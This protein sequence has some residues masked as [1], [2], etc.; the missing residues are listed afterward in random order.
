M[1]SL[2]K[3]MMMMMMMMI[4]GN[5]NDDDDDDGDD[6]DDDDDD[7]DCDDDGDGDDVPT[8]KGTA[9]LFL[10]SSFIPPRPFWQ[11]VALTTPSFS[12]ADSASDSHNPK[13]L[14]KMSV[15]TCSSS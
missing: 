4:D 7:G 10:L 11:P 3:M 8:L 2:M 15:F 12:G 14:N 6:S 5:D 1:V 9:T 13:S